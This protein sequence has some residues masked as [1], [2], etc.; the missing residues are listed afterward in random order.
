MLSKI[1]PLLI[2]IALSQISLFLPEAMAATSAKKLCANSKG[3]IVIKSKC[4]KS[5]KSV[6][7]STFKQV[8]STVDG[9]SGPAGV[10]GIEGSVGAQG[11][12]GS[13]GVPGVKGPKGTLNLAAC[14]VT[15]EGYDSNFFNLSNPVLYAE[16]YCNPS[17][18]FILEDEYKVIVF[19]GSVG[20]DIA[21]QARSPYHQTI[22]GDTREYA[23]GVFAN[24]INIV[25]NGAYEL[26]VRAICCPR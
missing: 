10:Q 4:S 2:V 23:V 5:E 9:L 26:R 16:A 24:R 19:P 12:Q 25:G 8:L 6:S 20:T 3:A 15:S 7:P 1:I 18:E 17:T 11:P 14:R 13:Q 22:N 21:I